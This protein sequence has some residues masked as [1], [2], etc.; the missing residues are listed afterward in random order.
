MLVGLGCGGFPIAA[1]FLASQS[2]PID[3]GESAILAGTPLVL[4]AILMCVRTGVLVDRQQGTFTRWLGVLVPLFI[5][6]ARHPFSRTGDVILTIN[7][8]HGS[9]G[10]R[11]LFY[12]VI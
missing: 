12:T 9:H 8:R 4:G 1:N 7:V 11:F 10:G 3:I 6:R 5:F 2:W